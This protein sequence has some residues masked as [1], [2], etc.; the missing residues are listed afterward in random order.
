[1]Q[2]QEFCRP[3]RTDQASTVDRLHDGCTLMSKWVVMCVFC[4]WLLSWKPAG[5]HQQDAQQLLSCMVHNPKQERCYSVG[6]AQGPDARYL[7]L[8]SGRPNMWSLMCAIH[9]DCSFLALKKKKI[10]NIKV[11]GRRWE[12]GP[13]MDVFNTLV[14]F[15][16]VG[17]W[18]KLVSHLAYW[19]LSTE[20]CRDLRGKDIFTNVTVKSQ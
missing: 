19:I 11:E 20:T 2:H 9:E 1:M 14:R 5:K 17:D 15:I 8:V 18:R 4:T 12:S 16:E 3:L 7:Q 6:F 13:E 10:K